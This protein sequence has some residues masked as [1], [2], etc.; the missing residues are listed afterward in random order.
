MT[1]REHWGPG[2][3]DVTGSLNSAGTA[4]V[5]AATTGAIFRT[6]STRTAVQG[7]MV[8]RKEGTTWEVL[9]GDTGWITI[10]ITAAGVTVASPGVTI[11]RMGL[12]V[13]II[14]D[15]ISFLAGF[16]SGTAVV[17]IPAGFRPAQPAFLPKVSYEGIGKN[18]I[19]SAAIAFYGSGALPDFRSTYSWFTYPAA[20][21]TTLTIT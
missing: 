7:A 3:P 12:R 15:R 18:A 4:W 1:S 2:R 9:E 13:E 8:W 5:A 14:V 20:W 6:T 11:R 16:A 17:P 21:P 19:A 10:P